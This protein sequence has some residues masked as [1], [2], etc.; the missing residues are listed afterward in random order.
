LIVLRLCRRLSLLGRFAVVL[1]ARAIPD[2][3]REEVPE[4]FEPC[5]WRSRSV[6]M[7]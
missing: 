6:K 3:Q 5:E 2:V 4:R 1:G 7:P